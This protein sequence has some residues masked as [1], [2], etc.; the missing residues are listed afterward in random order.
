MILASVA[1]GLA[2][3]PV[4]PCG[5]PEA[6]ARFRRRPDGASSFRGMNSIL[7]CHP[8]LH[9]APSLLLTLLAALALVQFAS[10]FWAE[11]QLTEG[12]AV[13]HGKEQGCFLPT[14]G[15]AVPRQ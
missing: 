1:S 11:C 5:A 10:R 4:L 8:R 3:W 14:H 9:G 2:C 15:A 12:E 7:F 6:V 13:S